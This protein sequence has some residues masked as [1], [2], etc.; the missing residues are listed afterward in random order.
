MT[1]KHDKDKEQGGKEGQS[2][3]E[4]QELALQIL[5]ILKDHKLRVAFNAIC[6]LTFALTEALE[7]EVREEELKHQRRN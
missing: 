1:D 6:I 7:D 2:M 5:E 4:E 3:S